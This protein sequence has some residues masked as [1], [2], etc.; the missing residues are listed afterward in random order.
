MSRRKSMGHATTRR[1]PVGRPG[2][3]PGKARGTPAGVAEKTH[4]AAR[5][6]FHSGQQEGFQ[7]LI[8]MLFLNKIFRTRRPVAGAEARRCDLDY[9]DGGYHSLMTT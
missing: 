4:P 7:W 2:E 9:G 5:P 3:G 8:F 1:S 6:E